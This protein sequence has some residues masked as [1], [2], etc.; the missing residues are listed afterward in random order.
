MG[1]SVMGHRKSI[2][3]GAAIVAEDTKQP[4]CVAGHE[5]QTTFWPNEVAK[6]TTFR[7]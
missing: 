2:R 1:V 4:E 6:F 3:S 5:T 7:F